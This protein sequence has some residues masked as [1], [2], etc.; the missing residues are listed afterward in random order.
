MARENRSG[1]LRVAK[2]RKNNTNRIKRFLSDKDFLKDLTTLKGAIAQGQ[3]LTEARVRLG[4]TSEVKWESL[5]SCLGQMTVSREKLFMEFHTR[6]QVRYQ[7]AHDLL[8]RSRP[9]H[10]DETG[11]KVLNPHHDT[12]MEAKMILVLI[13]LDEQAVDLADKLGLLKA[14]SDGAGG[15]GYS[16]EEVDAELERLSRTIEAQLASGRTPLAPLTIAD[17]TGAEPEREADQLGPLTLDA[18]DL[19]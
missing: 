17:V 6:N 14:K 19:K 3:N 11:K 10:L 12:D 1:L 4:I 5:T 15:E 13:K 9:H 16:S 18:D 7:Q 8:N 2:Q